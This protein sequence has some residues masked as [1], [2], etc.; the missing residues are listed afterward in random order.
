M[1]RSSSILRPTQGHPQEMPRSPPL[2]RPT[3]GHP[4]E[5]SRSPLLTL[6]RST[7]R[8]G[9]T[10]HPELPH[11]PLPPVL[12]QLYLTVMTR[13]QKRAKHTI[14]DPILSLKSKT[15][16]NVEI[17]DANPKNPNVP[18]EHTP[19]APKIGIPNPI[20]TSIPKLTPSKVKKLRG[21]AKQLQT[22]N[23]KSPKYSAYPADYFT[24]T[25]E[26]LNQVQQITNM[27]FTMDLGANPISNL[28]TPSIPMTLQECLHSNLNNTT[29]L[30]HGS[31]QN[32]RLSLTFCR[33]P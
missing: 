30:I 22:V 4:Q 19:S 14:T 1:P 2:L 33:L 9:H 6:L 27:V 26:T 12:P 23:P 25:P 28:K 10:D 15:T 20:P 8:P 32:V 5:M 24:L 16:D 3:Q 31:L 11:P 21:Q 17:N 7:K 13:G 18:S 29:P